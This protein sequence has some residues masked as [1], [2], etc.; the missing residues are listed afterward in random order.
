M[1]TKRLPETDEERVKALQV[2]IKQEELNPDDSVLSIKELHELRTF[3]HFFEGD[4]FCCKQATDDEL[5]AER[6][7]TDL[8]KMA[9]LYISHFIQVLYLAVI[10][11]EV[12]AD[13]L[14]LYELDEKEMKLPD[15]S[16]EEAVLEWGN[17][18]IQGETE[19]TYLGGVPIYTPAIAKVKIHYDLFKDSLQSLKI[20]KK[21]TL[22]MEEAIF[23]KRELADKYILDIWNRIEEKCWG[24]AY[25][26]KTKKYDDY[27]IVFIN[28]P[29][30]VQL[31]VF[32]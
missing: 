14:Y 31:N 6:A 19:R 17:R 24:L 7:Y 1:P 20:F 22:R 13:N 16:T 27:K 29:K 2:I 11:N 30:T 21:N 15:L 3:L 23:E 10:R 32:D 18:I 28:S 25:E 4:D 9:Q 26:E 8:F 12:K 5:K